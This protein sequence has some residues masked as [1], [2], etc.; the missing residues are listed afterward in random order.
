MANLPNSVGNY[1][2]Y[3]GRKF[4]RFQRLHLA[5]LPNLKLARE[6]ANKAHK[7]EAYLSTVRIIFWKSHACVV[8]FVSGDE[9]IT[10]LYVMPL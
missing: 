8:V 6:I 4:L 9:D 5:P 1:T 7:R 3:G 10:N 2:L